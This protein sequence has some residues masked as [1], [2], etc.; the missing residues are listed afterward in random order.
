[1]NRRATALIDSIESNLWIIEAKLS[2]QRSVLNRTDRTLQRT[3]AEMEQFAEIDAL[4]AKLMERLD[5]L[6]KNKYESTDSEVDA[7][8]R[9]WANFRKAAQRMNGK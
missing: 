5:A 8:K 4:K 3:K 7:A 6:R 9:A 1:M 2:A